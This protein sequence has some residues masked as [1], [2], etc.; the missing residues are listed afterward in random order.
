[1]QTS[2]DAIILGAGISGLALAERLRKKNKTFV[3]LEKSAGVGGRLATR[4]GPDCTFDHG[5]Q[6]IK[7]RPSD[8]TFWREALGDSQD[9]GHVWFSQQDCD[10]VVFPKG[11]TQLPKALSAASEL[12]LN[13]KVVQFEGSKDFCTVLCESGARYMAKK[14]YLTC[15]LPQSLALLKSSQIEF[16]AEL[17]SIEY[18]SALVGLFRVSSTNRQIL[19]F[20][21]RQ[22]YS[23]HIFSISNQ[24]SKGVSQNLAFSM[25]MQP[26][27]SREHF[28]NN[29]TTTEQEITEHFKNA[30]REIAGDQDFTLLSSQLKKWRYSHPLS[31]AQNLFQALPSTENI[32]LLGDAFGGG[33][34]YGALRSALAIPLND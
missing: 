33:H 34:I 9:L 18:A 22:D 13:E 11:M 16:P 20:K 19:D 7:K 25:V 8:E 5:A 31:T 27:W 32:C 24:Q 4:R 26:S 1:M 29:D 10:Y 17:Q 30:L 15:P 2:Y 3:I 23:S 12:K 6:F 28:E 21:Y 14:V